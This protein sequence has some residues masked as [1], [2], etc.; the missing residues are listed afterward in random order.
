MPP[1]DSC[2]YAFTSLTAKDKA[3][4]LGEILVLF[5]PKRIYTPLNRLG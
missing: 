2:T 1:I 4:S 5:I 3:L